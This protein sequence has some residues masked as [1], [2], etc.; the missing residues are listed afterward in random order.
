MTH[1]EFARALEKFL[2]QN[3]LTQKEFAKQAGISQPRL[4]EWK[5]GRM[6]RL[7]S[8]AAEAIR[9]IEDYRKD[10]RTAIPERIQKAVKETWDGTDSHA[11]AIAVVIESLAALR[12]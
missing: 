10:E 6:K 2:E 9:F 7:P 3:H 8:R 11:K 5:N 12:I 1:L 4:S